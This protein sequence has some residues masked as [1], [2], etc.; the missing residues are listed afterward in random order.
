M[1]PAHVRIASQSRKSLG[2]MFLSAGI[3]FHGKRSLVGSNLPPITS[4]PIGF[5]HGYL[6]R[7]P[8][9]RFR[10]S[11]HTA[12]SALS[13]GPPAKMANGSPSLKAL[14]CRD[15]Y[16]AASLWRCIIYNAAPTP[17]CPWPRP[18]LCSHK[19]LN[20]R[21]RKERKEIGVPNCSTST[22]SCYAMESDD[23]PTIYSPTRRSLRSLR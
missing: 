21:E 2:G 13:K 20:H 18:F 10:T 12:A 3:R 1:S 19:A 17:P 23:S 14:L 16:L 15:K 8:S 6:A 22:S 4:T 5:N 9:N 11:A 7:S